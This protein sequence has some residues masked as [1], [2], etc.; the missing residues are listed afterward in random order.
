MHVRLEE[1]ITPKSIRKGQSKKS[2]TPK[3]GQ[4]ILLF[5]TNFKSMSMH[6]GT[7]MNLRSK[8]NATPGVEAS[9]LGLNVNIEMPSSK[10]G[11]TKVLL[12]LVP[13]EITSLKV[14]K[15]KVQIKA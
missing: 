9:R 8:P 10:L 6:I 13:F 7:I 15:S 1:W 4:E 2:L 14:L 5:N 3:K 12:T 11:A